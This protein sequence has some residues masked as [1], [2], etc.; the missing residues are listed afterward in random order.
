M[1][2][3]VLW[4]VLAVLI[5]GCEGPGT[6][7]EYV[8]LTAEAEATTRAEEPAI[9]AEPLSAPEP[10]PLPPWWI[11]GGK[12][13]RSGDGVS[14]YQAGEYGD[15]WFSEGERAYRVWMTHIQSGP[16]EHS[17]HLWLAEYAV[18]DSGYEKIVSVDHAEVS[19]EAWSVVDGVVIAGYERFAVSGAGFR[20][21]E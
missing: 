16:V 13:W 12:L 8:Y 19:G 6:V 5:A 20:R 15:Y 11:E 9:Q 14:R 18:T 4:F 17:Y 7:T 21:V 3:G 1:K 10:D 2:H